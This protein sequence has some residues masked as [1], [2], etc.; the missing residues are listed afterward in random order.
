MEYTQNYEIWQRASLG[1]LIINQEKK[2][3]GLCEDHVLA[4]KGHVLYISRKRALWD[5]P[6]IVKFDMEHPGA[7]IL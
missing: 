4:K 6:R 7:H 2:I 1:T 3:E 5:T